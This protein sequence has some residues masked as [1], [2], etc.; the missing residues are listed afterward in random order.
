MN[1]EIYEYATNKDN[2][3]YMFYSSGKKGIIPKIVIYEKI[4]N[5]HYNLA[6]GDY[7]TLGKSLNDLIITNNGD[8]I[9]VLG[10]VIN[11]IQ[12]FFATY[13]YAMLEIRGSTAIRTKLYQKIIKDNWAYIE[14]DFRILAFK[15]GEDKPEIPDFIQDYDFFQISRK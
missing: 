6:F 15:D 4:A 1:T 13:P 2:L 5:N 12:K 7:D 3:V 8:A 10:T 9:K 11:T 14:T